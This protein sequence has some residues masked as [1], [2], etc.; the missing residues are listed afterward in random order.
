MLVE[1]CLVILVEIEPFTDFE[2]HVVFSAFRQTE[3]N[4]TPGAPCDVFLF[5]ITWVNVNLSVWVVMVDDLG[6]SSNL[7]AKL[8][9]DVVSSLHCTVLRYT[10]IVEAGALRNSS[11]AAYTMLDK[12]VLT[13]DVVTAFRLPV[14]VNWVLALVMR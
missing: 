12:L 9:Y 2:D 8:G 14:K 7:L 13:E 3:R 5:D 4:L 6:L 11:F 10:V 1:I